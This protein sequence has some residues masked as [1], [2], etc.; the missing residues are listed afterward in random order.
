MK[1]EAET[2]STATTPIIAD[3][4]I[5]RMT[6][7]LGPDNKTRYPGRLKMVFDYIGLARAGDE[8]YEALRIA[9]LEFV[10]LVKEK[11][12]W[13]EDTLR[14]FITY[15]E[16]RVQKGEIKRITIRN[17]IKAVKTFCQMNRIARFIEW[18]L[19]SKGLPSGRAPSNDRA[20]TAEELKRL[21]G[22]DLRLKVIICIMT[23][24]GI[25]VGAWNYLKVKHIM[26]IRKGDV[27]LAWM[28]VY[29]EQYRGKSKQYNTLISPEAYQAFRDYLD[30]RAASGEKITGESW[31]LRDKW[32]RTN[33]RRSGHRGLAT[34]PKQLKEGAIKRSID[35]ALWKS[36][37]RVTPS[38]R[39]EFKEC[40]GMRK[41]FKTYAQRT[42]KEADVERLLGHAGGWS[43]A[44]YNRPPDDWL[45]E[46]Y[47]KAV[48]DLTIYKPLEQTQ[49]LAQELNAQMASNDRDSS[50]ERA[51]SDYE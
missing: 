16:Q 34:I 1:L 19:I 3:D 15:Q 44:A 35:D 41:Y 50:L 51:K 14:D 7:S 10:K 5:K 25:R 26:P 36:G 39:H 11:P 31:V 30:L 40:H 29:A 6:W 45:V 22:D 48:P 27:S 17:Y 9:A 2:T 28:M 20:P 13:V 18:T 4:P 23:S 38:K 21:I 33:V 8:D 12:E 42:M 32:Q 24:C 49:A 46:E 37:I 43:N 47:L